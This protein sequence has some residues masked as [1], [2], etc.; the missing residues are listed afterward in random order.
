M[1]EADAA[2]GAVAARMMDEALRLAEQGLY[3]TDPNPRVGCVLAD[4]DRV[5]GT[6]WHERAGGAHAEIAAL[7]RA[8]AAA[9]GATAYVT[10]EPC[11]HHGRTPPCADALIDAGVAEVV[12]AVRDPHP[13]VDGNGLKRLREA[14]IRT[15]VGLRA[16]PARDLN[17]GFF[18][19]FERGRPWVRAK[20][21][22][23]LD[24]RTAGP[25]GRS[26]WIT[27]EMAR[28]DG[29]LWRARAS[30]V[31][32]GIETVLADDPR[33]DARVDRSHSTALVVV[34]DGRGRLPVTS[35]LLDTGS[36]VLHAVSSGAPASPRG[37][38]RVE[39]ESGADGGVDLHELLRELAR[40]EVNELH[41]EAGATLTGA[42][43]AAGLVDELLLY[44]ASCLIGAE[45]APLVR[46]PGVEK[47]DQRLHLEL[48]E[49]REL[50]PDRCLRLAPA[51]RSPCARTPKPEH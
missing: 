23:S 48:L 39:L 12:C 40:R 41:V 16:G 14:G 34:A 7:D 29:H 17:P 6:G 15:R 50:G 49:V 45:G 35:R 26:K 13:Q 8:G 31:L 46:L 30:A 5:V 22:A 32:T 10:L 27:G 19:R 18:S 42:L 37:C 11:S 51:S 33:L 1:T 20:L 36:P 21:A 24:G 25:E 4:G 47:L 38:D 3:T 28:A 9:R 43:L 44:Q 2:F